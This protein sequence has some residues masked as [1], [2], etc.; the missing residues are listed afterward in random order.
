MRMALGL[1]A[2]LAVAALAFGLLWPHLTL[3]PALARFAAHAGIAAM[4]AIWLALLLA[5]F[6]GTSRATPIA[7]AGFAGGSTSTS[8]SGA[9]SSRGATLAAGLTSRG[10]GS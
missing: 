5:A 6:F 9:A 1:V 4:W 3:R 7:G 2:A 10:A 8:I